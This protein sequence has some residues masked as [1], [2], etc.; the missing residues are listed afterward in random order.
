MK[1]PTLGYLANDQAVKLTTRKFEE[2]NGTASGPRRQT[3]N[4]ARSHDHR[5]ARPSD[6]H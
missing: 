4:M 5:F 1:Y 2:S 6:G 3:A